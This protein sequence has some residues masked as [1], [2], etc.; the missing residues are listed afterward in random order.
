MLGRV[1]RQ[2]TD[3]RSGAERAG[4]LLLL[5]ADLLEH[6]EHLAHHVGERDGGRGHDDA[7]HREDDGDAAG[8]QPVAEPARLAVDE[9]ERQADDDGGDGEGDVDQRIEQPGAGEAVAGE[10]E[11]DAHPEHRVERYGDDGHEQREP[12]RVQCVRRGDGIPC[13]AESVLEGAEEHRARRAGGRA[14]Q[15]GEHAER[16][17]AGAS[18][19]RFTPTPGRRSAGGPSRWRE[20]DQGDGDEHDGHRARRREVPALGEAVDEGRGDLGLEREVARDEHDGAELADGAGEGEAGAGEDRR[21]DA[22][23]DDAAQYLARRGAEGGRSLFGLRI[24]LGQDRLDAADAEGQ[25]HEE[26][27]GSRCRAGCRPG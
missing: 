3:E 5:G 23:E 27:R 6:R 20:H 10:D 12:E 11:R 18:A 13:R 19:E 17:A 2:K 8:G 4:R 26:Q 21:Q 9:D 15:V 25:C 16:A 22:R 14:G 1:M 24:E 7:R